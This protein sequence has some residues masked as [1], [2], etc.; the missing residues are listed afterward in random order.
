MAANG[1]NSLIVP[2]IKNN[3]VVIKEIE[4][5]YSEQWQKNHY[6][7]ILSAYKNSAFYD[8]YMPE[9]VCVFNKKYKYL[10]DLNS[11]I[12]EIIFNILKYN[13]S[14]SYSDKYIE[15]KSIKDY[16]NLLHPKSHKDIIENDFKQEEYIQVFSE[17]HGFI[18]D[19]SILDL[20]F[21][22]GPLSIS[23]LKNSILL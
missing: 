4:I 23:V 14:F 9:I 7:T 6:R 8:F 5:D 22:M 18:A 16:R 15:D 21:N 19:L 20:I 10:I 2:V 12:L 3:N 13:P 1:I 17:R 11:N